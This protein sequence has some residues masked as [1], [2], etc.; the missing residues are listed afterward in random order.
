[1]RDVSGVSGA[2]PI[3]RD[4]M[5]YLH[6]DN[7]STS[8][9]PPRGIVAQQVHFSPDIESPR[10]E[11]FLAGTETAE[12]RLIAT[13]NTDQQVHAKILYPT[14]GTIIAMDPD[15]PVNHQ[16][17]QFS[18]SGSENIVWLIDGVSAGNGLEVNWSPTGGRHK[19]MLTDLRGNEL[20]TVNFEVRGATTP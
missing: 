5:D 14:S 15:I 4:L 3:W 1:M 2:A 17:V 20:D 7:T 13:N 6:R 8:P 9:K 16:R 10:T 19:L 11:S 18:S 12:I